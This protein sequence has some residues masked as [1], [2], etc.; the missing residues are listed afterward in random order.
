VLLARFAGLPPAGLRYAQAASALGTSFLPEVAAQMA[1]MAGGEIG[2]RW[3]RWSGLIRQEPGAEAGF[4]HPL[5]R[6]A[7]AGGQLA[8]PL[9]EARPLRGRGR[10]IGAGWAPG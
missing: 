2:T 9:A 5:F 10:R 6:Q 4:V 3:R 8:D 7:L 1:G